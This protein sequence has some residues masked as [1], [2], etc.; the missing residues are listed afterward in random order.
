MPERIT[1]HYYKYYLTFFNWLREVL[2]RKACQVRRV[3]QGV[4]EPQ[5]RMLSQGLQVYQEKRLIL[6]FFASV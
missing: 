6:F 4:K 2:E 1:A 3:H 5:E